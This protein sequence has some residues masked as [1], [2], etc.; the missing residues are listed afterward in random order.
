MSTYRELTY[1]VLDELHLS[2]DDSTITPEH[3]TFL[4]DKYRALLL[5]QAYK[6]L[7]KPIP[8]SNYQTVCLNLTVAEGVDGDPCSGK[9]LRSIESIPNIID[10][11][12]PR[13]GTTDAFGG[14]VT[15]VSF[16]RF[17]YVGLNKWLKN[18]IYCTIGQDGKL[19]MKSSNPQAY[20]L[21]EAKFSGVFEDAQEA[22]KLSCDGDGNNNCDIMDSDFP[23][24]EAFVP[25]L[26][27][28]VVKELYGTLYLPSD[29]A[30]NAADD[31]NNNQNI[32]QPRYRR[33]N[34]D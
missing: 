16:E 21:D 26:I 27:S 18:F 29:D 30:N 28:S 6:D 14:E 20:Y 34:N 1:M 23:I 8:E 15:Y 17:K 22:A 11:G 24:E 31:L 9:Y 13:V 12:T 5:K 33:S 3:I 25:T 7:K 19:Y 10:I 4:L 32:Y 2:V